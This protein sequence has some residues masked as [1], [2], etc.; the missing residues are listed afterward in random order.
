MSEATKL[1]QAASVL[2]RW[3]AQRDVS[4]LSLEALRAEAGFADGVADLFVLFGGGVT[5]TLE[6][7]AAAMRAGAARRYAIVGGRGH[8]T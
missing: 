4:A 1:A 3:C 2:A 7:L 8:A 6:T 5:G